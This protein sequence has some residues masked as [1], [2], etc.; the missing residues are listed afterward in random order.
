MIGALGIDVGGTKTLCL[1]VNDRYRI[2]AKE[3][4][5][6]AP[7]DGRK[8]FVKK[9]RGAA[10]ALVAAAER[11]KIDLLGAG[12][13][14]AGRVNEKQ[15]TVES[16]PNLL[17]LEGLNLAR[18][19]K[20]ELNL[21]VRLGNDV[22]LA[23]YAEHQ[24][25]VARACQHVLG[26][27]FGTGV[28]GAAIV[29]GT[30]YTGATGMGGQLG[31]ILTHHIGGVDTLADYAIL[32]RVA[33]KAAIAGA[34]L[35][36]AAK[37]W[38]PNLYKEV[39]TDLAK[40]TWGALRRAIRKGDKQIEDLLRARLRI[41]GSALSNVVNF[42]NPELLVLGGGLAEEMPQLVRSEISRGLKQYLPPEILRPLTV[43]VARFKNE[44][45]ALGAAHLVFERAT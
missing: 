10:G 17:F 13:A 19:F 37:Q 38:A 36:L 18:L 27:F 26:V 42:M 7:E 33:S 16:A 3:K 23:L 5:Q 30:L 29:N 9:L 34:A 39:G 11:M 6:T 25:G 35:G 22:Q 24:F 14:V 1:L 12:L 15:G 2:A 40:V 32:D 44:S 43:K 45:G 20:D 21:D 28:A 8:K 41:A 4:F 31:S